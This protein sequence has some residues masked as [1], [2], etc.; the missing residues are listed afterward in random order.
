MR[1][2]AGFLVKKGMDPESALRAITAAAAEILGIEDRVGSL[3]AGKDADMVVLNGEPLNSLS[4]VDMV[5]VDGSV[6]WKKE[7]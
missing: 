2:Y 5:F 6:V 3:E 7:R 1:F 4:I